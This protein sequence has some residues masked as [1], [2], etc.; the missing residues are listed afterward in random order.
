MNREEAKYLLRAYRTSGKDASSP[1][2]QET[3]EVARQDPALA[4]WFLHEQ[5]LDSEIGRGLRA[6]SAPPELKS[7]LLALQR[8]IQPAPWWRRRTALSLIAASVALL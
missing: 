8:I 1:E 3:L 7:Q 2:F 4:D 6:F 5:G